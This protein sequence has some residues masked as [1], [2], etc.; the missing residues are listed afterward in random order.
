MSVHRVPVI[1]MAGQQ[2]RQQPAAAAPGQQQG[3]K[4]E[5]ETKE[6]GVAAAATGTL[7]VVTG[8]ATMGTLAIA[9]AAAAVGYSAGQWLME[10][11]NDAEDAKAA[12]EGRPDRQD[13]FAKIPRTAYASLTQWQMYLAAQVAESQVSHERMAQLF[14]DF[15]AQQPAHA[16]NIRAFGTAEVM[17]AIQDGIG[18][19][20]V[21]AAQV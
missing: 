7:A 18:V 5:W 17:Q 21:A 20:V 6:Y 2:A 13:V 16:A 1:S 8:F 12:K 3:G 10:K 15:E 9:G 11:Y 4:K 19:T 14:A